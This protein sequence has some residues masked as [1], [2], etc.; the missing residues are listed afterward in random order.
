MQDNE[1]ENN[2]EIRTFVENPYDPERL[3]PEDVMRHFFVDDVPILPVISK[4]GTLLGILRKDDLVSELSDIERV[5]KQKTDQ[6]VQKLIKKMDVDDLLQYVAKHK[7]FSVINIFGEHVGKWSWLQLL[8]ASESAPKKK[9]SSHEV[10]KQ[11]DLEILEWIIYSILEHIPRPL[12]AINNNGK[13]MFYNGHFEELLQQSL[14]DDFDILSVEKIFSDAEKNDFYY[15]NKDEILFYNHVL[16]I[17]YEKIP[18][19][20]NNRQIG[21]LIFCDKQSNIPLSAFLTEKNLTKQSLDERLAVLEKII[22]SET[23]KEKDYNID[24]AAKALQIP[25]K[26]LQEKISVYGLTESFQKKEKK[27]GKKK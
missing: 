12:Y 14:G 3:S 7:E 25:K 11:K 10:T 16:N 27:M 17:Y 23:I 13:T 19:K 8:E 24:E 18:M 5:R 22:I 15:N 21:F 26:K 20:S 2:N 9:Q 4:A 1:F 6:I